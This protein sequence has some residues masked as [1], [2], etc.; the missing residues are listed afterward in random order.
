M[1]LFLIS[2]SF[3]TRIPI[4]VRQPVTDDEFFK[5][6]LFLPLDGLLV[7]ILN[8]IVAYILN[9]ISFKPLSAI[10]TLIFYIYI[11]GSLHL[12]GVAD[13]FDAIFSGADKERMLQIMK[14]SRLGSFGAIA[15][16]LVVLSQLICFYYLFDHK[17]L[18]A[19][20][21]FPV[22]GK[23]SAIELGAFGK[24]VESNHGLGNHFCN[25]DKPWIAISYGALIV[26]ALVLLRDFNFLIAY[27][28]VL[29]FVILEIFYFNKKLGGISGDQFGM[30]IEITQILFLINYIIV[31]EFIKW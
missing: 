16:I 5:A 29:L 14:D 27:G 15:L 24:P 30:T 28:I 31:S 13:T 8:Y 17:V 19:F 2:V 18:V 10:L 26:L 3:F 1:R 23:Y 11:T 7:G 6:M 12:D 20:I 22:I 21:L 9:F 4:R 25:V